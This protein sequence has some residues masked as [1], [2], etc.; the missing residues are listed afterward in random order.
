MVLRTILTRTIQAGTPAC[1]IPPTAS[2]TTAGGRALAP[3]PVRRMVLN[4]GLAPGALYMDGKAESLD[5][6]V[7]AL[8]ELMAGNS[9]SGAPHP[10]EAVNY[11]LRRLRRH[12]DQLNP[13]GRAKRNVAHNDDLN[14]RF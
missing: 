6:S 5:C 11:Q 9:W 1:S 12:L 10:M 4:L 14:G 8:P 13:A 7:L 2:A 3:H